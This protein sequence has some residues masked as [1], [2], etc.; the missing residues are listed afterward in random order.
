VEFPWV[1]WVPRGGTQW[2]CPIWAL[3]S[4]NVWLWF[5]VS[6][7]ISLQRKALCDDCARHRSMSI[8]NLTDLSLGIILSI[9]SLGIWA[10][11][12]RL[13][14]IQGVLRMGSLLKCGPQ[15]K[16]VTG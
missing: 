4:P 5:S 16:P 8:A 2:R 12:L 9:F 11:Q 14:I 1:P 7:P 3:L 10:I 6:A 15:I 13:L